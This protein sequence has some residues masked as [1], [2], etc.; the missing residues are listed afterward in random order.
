MNFHHYTIATTME[1]AKQAIPQGPVAALEIIKNLGTNGGGFFNANGA[2]PYENPTLLTN[3]FEMLAIALLPAALTN[4][5]GRMVGQP[6]HGWQADQSTSTPGHQSLDC[7]GRLRPR[8]RSEGCERR[9]NHGAG[10]K[11]SV[12]ASLM[13]FP[14]NIAALA[15]HPRSHIDGEYPPDHNQ[16]AV[17]QTEVAAR[18]QRLLLAAV[19]NRKTHSSID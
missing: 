18:L 7:S 15:K 14:D 16:R 17:L 2:H 10:C 1:G 13:P 3:F 9:I 11:S 19:R 8:A 12:R 4:T 5:F 6:R